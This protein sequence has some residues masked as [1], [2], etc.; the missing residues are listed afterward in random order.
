MLAN[1]YETTYS[2]MA[3]ELD[4]LH[5]VLEALHTLRSSTQMLESIVLGLI[6]TSSER[7]L[8]RLHA[9][10]TP[11]QTIEQRCSTAS[12]QRPF[13][14]KRKRF[15]TWKTLTLNFI[16]TGLI[17]SGHFTA[18]EIKENQENLISNFNNWDLW[19]R[20][21]KGL[22][23]NQYKQEVVEQI[24]LSTDPVM[25]IWGTEERLLECLQVELSMGQV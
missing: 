3:Y 18:A 4:D 11:S 16:A 1:T 22:T 2:E 24:Y 23:F 19:G 5:K 10:K 20:S 8:K 25:L 17:E 12:K 14:S 6:D 13:L 21:I 7:T 9:V 15:S